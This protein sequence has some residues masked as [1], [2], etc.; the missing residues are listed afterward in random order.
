MLYADTTFGGV[1]IG[2]KFV[3]VGSSIWR[4]KSD[5]YGGFAEGHGYAVYNQDQKVVIDI[6]KKADIESIE[7]VRHS[8]DL[9]KAAYKEWSDK[10]E[11]VQ[12][13]ANEGKLGL[14]GSLGKHR[15]DILRELAEEALE[16]RK[17]RQAI[18]DALVIR[19]LGVAEGNP[20]GELGKIIHWEVDVN[21]D[22]TLSDRA[23]ALIDQGY[24]EAKEEPEQPDVFQQIKEMKIM[25]G[26]DEGIALSFFMPPWA[27]DANM[28]YEV[29]VGAQ[30]CTKDGRRMGNA[31]VVGTVSKGHG[32]YFVVLT[33]AGNKVTMTEQEIRSAF[34]ISPWISDV[35][36]V[37][38]KF[39][40]RQGE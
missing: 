23:Q 38:R 7:G 32:D 29:V 27:V 15:A 21:L 40:S 37:V 1:P 28:K 31:H 30:L 3:P 13:W 19:Y 20:K 2:Y 4:E 11:F 36:E 34:Y 6:A 39:G 16:N 25:F 14:A 35:E 17:Y 12:E 9:Y 24:K 33:D 5:Y 22:P 8:L 18:D 26:I 10:T